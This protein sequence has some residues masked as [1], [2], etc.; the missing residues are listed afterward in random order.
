MVFGQQQVVQFD[1][2]DIVP[3]KGPRHPGFSASRMPEDEADVQLPRIEVV[4]P[5]VEIRLR[6]NECFLRQLQVLQ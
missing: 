4:F 5:V 1:M 6:N 2:V 3:H